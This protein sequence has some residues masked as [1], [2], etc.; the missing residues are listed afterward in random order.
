[1]KRTM[2]ATALIWAVFLGGAGMAFAQDGGFKPDN[3][4]SEFQTVG[5]VLLAVILGVFGLVGCGI[6]IQSLTDA[7]KQGGWGHVVVGIAM[8]LIA[9]L[10]IWSLIGFT[11]QNPDEVSNQLKVKGK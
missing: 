6:I 8:V 9:G 2:L 7:R 11:G 3:I 4:L 10:A 1:M 5:K